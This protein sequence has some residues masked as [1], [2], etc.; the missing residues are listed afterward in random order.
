MKI[1][2]EAIKGDT[3]E[4][5]IRITA[6]YGLRRSEVLGIK[7]GSID[8]ESKLLTIRHTVVFYKA[9]VEKDSTKTASSHRSFLLTDEAVEIF[10]SLKESEN[11]NR[12]LFR[13]AYIE[14]DYVFKWENGKPFEP[15]YVSR[16]FRKLLKDHNLPHIRF[17]ELRHSCASLLL[18]SGFTLKDVQ[19]YMGHAN[20]RMTADIYGHLDLAR[21]NLLSVQISQSIFGPLEKPLELAKN[22]NCRSAKTPAISMVEYRGFEPL[23]S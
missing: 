23:T 9:R 5:L 14:N 1:L 16:H 17:H 11:E 8:F 19:E 6:L 12:K 22:E 21:K 7:W 18:N 10:R 15:D 13:T 2:F 3:L 20:I 4:Y